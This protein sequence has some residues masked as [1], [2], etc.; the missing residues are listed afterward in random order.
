MSV[1]LRDMQM[2]ALVQE[3]LADLDTLQRSPEKVGGKGH[4]TDKIPSTFSGAEVSLGPRR[5]THNHMD[6]V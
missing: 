3:E 6:R 4:I 5:D 1:N 2:C